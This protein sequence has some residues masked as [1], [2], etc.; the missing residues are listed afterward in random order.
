VTGPKDKHLKK[1][2]E[3]HVRPVAEQE[4]KRDE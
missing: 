4:V 1:H 2:R 3:A